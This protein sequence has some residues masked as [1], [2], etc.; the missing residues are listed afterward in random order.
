MVKNVFLLFIASLMTIVMSP[1]ILSATDDVDLTG[2]SD[3]KAVE[4]VIAEPEP[5]PVVTKAPV[6]GYAPAAPVAMAATPAN[7]I[8]IAGRTIEI[9]GVGSTTVDAGNH[10]NKYGSLLYGHNSTGV[11][12]GILN[13]GVGSTFTVT[14][15]GVT[16]TYRVANA[17]MFEKNNGLLQVNGSGDF[18]NA[19]SRAVYM[20]THYS[21]ALM[22]CAGTSYGNGDASHRYVLFA[23]AI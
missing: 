10:V 18:M 21:I 15:G 14:Y 11:F 16:T 12:G 22:T 5:E 13:I 20:G 3:A 17:V 1:K 2:V 23:N 9:V 19:T 8:Q 4:T 6:A 7:N